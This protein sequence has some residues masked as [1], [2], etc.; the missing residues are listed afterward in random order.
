[1]KVGDLVRVPPHVY[2]NNPVGWCIGVV[3]GKVG[4]KLTIGTQY[5]VDYWDESDI[6]EIISEVK[7]VKKD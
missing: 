5:G 6:R 1:M 2:G 7:K 3:V 4:Y